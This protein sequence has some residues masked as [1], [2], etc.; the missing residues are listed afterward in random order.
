MEVLMTTNLVVAV[1]VVVVVVE[2]I[3]KIQT[4]IELVNTCEF[5]K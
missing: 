2:L 4:D 1:V 3:E 5:L